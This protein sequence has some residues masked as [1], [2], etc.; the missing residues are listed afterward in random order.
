MKQTKDKVMQNL[1]ED[2]FD[3]DF[4]I[5]KG[6]IQNTDNGMDKL[7]QVQPSAQLG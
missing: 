3:K 5:E 6:W 7:S 2:L 4:G 1:R